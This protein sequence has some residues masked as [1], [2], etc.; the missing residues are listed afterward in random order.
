[1]IRP[2]LAANNFQWHDFA[3]IIHALEPA[4]LKSRIMG[5]H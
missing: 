3:S 4:I 5:S 1:M 2:P